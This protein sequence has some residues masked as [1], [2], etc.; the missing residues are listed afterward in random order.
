METGFVVLSD[1]I[2]LCVCVC[3]LKAAWVLCPIPSGEGPHAQ[4]GWWWDAGSHSISAG[5]QSAS[6]LLQ[7]HMDAD[8]EGEALTLPPFPTLLSSWGELRLCWNPE[9]SPSSSSSS[10]SKAF[11]AGQQQMERLLSS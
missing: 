11:A 10:S 2:I 5:P 4:S 1:R 7:L 8:A 6:S 9:Q 3:I